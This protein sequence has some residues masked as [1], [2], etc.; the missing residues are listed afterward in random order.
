MS[1]I[2]LFN[3]VLLLH[4]HVDNYGMFDFLTPYL[5]ILAAKDPHKVENNTPMQ[6]L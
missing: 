2:M 3:I 1:G 5:N 4:I 6:A